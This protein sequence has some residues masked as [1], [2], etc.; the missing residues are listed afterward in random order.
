MRAFGFAKKSRK[1]FTLV[2]AIV[3]IAVFAIAAVMIAM[4][5]FTAT[6]MVR[7]S[8]VF[9]ADR[10]ALME[11]AAR[12]E[13]NENIDITVKQP[14]DDDYETFTLVLDGSNTIEYVDGK[15]FIYTVKS[16]GRQYYLFVSD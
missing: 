15:Y 13:S 2:E 11:A 9:D 1:G 3:G 6:N 7:Y 14:G 4:I 16:T 12:G 8:L 5:L 10:E